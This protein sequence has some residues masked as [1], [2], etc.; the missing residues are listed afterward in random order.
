[1]SSFAQERWFNSAAREGSPGLAKK[2]FEGGHM[3]SFA[4]KQ[5]SADQAL[6]IKNTGERNNHRVALQNRVE[7]NRHQ[8]SNHHIWRQRGKP[9]TLAPELLRQAPTDYSGREA[10]KGLQDSAT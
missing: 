4:A 1:M 3:Q 8:S 6:I 7:P 9:G 10:G 2:S 5:H